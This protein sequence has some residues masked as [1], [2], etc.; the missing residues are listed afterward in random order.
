[1][2]TLART[3]A[4]D[5]ATGTGLTK[6]LHGTACKKE[7]N[8]RHAKHG[9]HPG[10]D[11]FNVPIMVARRQLQKTLW[12]GVLRN[13]GSNAGFVI[14]L[15][16]IRHLQ[17]TSSRDWQRNENAVRQSWQLRCEDHYYEVS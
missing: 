13:L 7:H 1:M 16:R 9:A 8:V 11:M 15:R 6:C 5:S 10:T 3:E 2:L 4:D 12:I 17:K 14:C